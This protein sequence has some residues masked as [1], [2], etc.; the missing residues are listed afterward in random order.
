[1]T[2]DWILSILKYEALLFNNFIL[3]LTHIAQ[4]RSQKSTAVDAYV[5]V[6]LEAAKCADVAS[7]W[8]LE[9]ADFVAYVFEDIAVRDEC[10]MVCRLFDGLEEL[11][12]FCIG[13]DYYASYCILF[14]FSHPI[15]KF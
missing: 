1:M 3:I 2:I 15:A 4:F 8:S 10:H 6:F 13:N 14:H 7:E 9:D 11:R 5:F 12:H